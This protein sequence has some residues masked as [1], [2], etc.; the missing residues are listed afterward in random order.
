MLPQFVKYFDFIDDLVTVKV[1]LNYLANCIYNY[2]LEYVLKTCNA[3]FHAVRVFTSSARLHGWQLNLTLTAICQ[4]GFAKI[5]I[6][7]YR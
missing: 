3:L 6:L 7:V 4:S 2:V 5:H 1:R